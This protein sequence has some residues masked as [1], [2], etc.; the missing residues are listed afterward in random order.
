[1]ARRLDSYESSWTHVIVPSSTMVLRVLLSLLDSA[2]IPRGL[3][4][5]VCTLQV[6][7]VFLASLELLDEARSAGMR[8][9][10]RPA[11][12]AALA[13][14]RTSL[15]HGTSG[16]SVFSAR[17]SW[18]TR[19]WRSCPRPASWSSPRSSTSSTCSWRRPSPPPARCA[20]GMRWYLRCCCGGAGGAVQERRAASERALEV[21]EQN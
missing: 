4:R 14:A 15:D 1:M 18:A 10:F 20:E 9:G 7:K 5:R 21:N 3:I 16:T 11:I 6:A 8:F 2:G 12:F 17:R 13:R 19:R